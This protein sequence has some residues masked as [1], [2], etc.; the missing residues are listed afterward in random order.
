M[1]MNPQQP[2]AAHTPLKA[3][4]RHL[5]AFPACAEV[6]GASATGMDWSDVLDSI[7]DAILVH[8]LASGRVLHANAGACRMF[9][10]DLGMLRRR[11]FGELG[12]GT[13]PHGDED[14]RRWFERATA[15]GPQLFEWLARTAD[16]RCFWTEVGLHVGPGIAA[17]RCFATVRDISRRKA[18]AAESERATEALRLSEERFRLLLGRMPTVAVQ[19]CGPDGTVRYWNEASERLYGYSAAEAVGRHLVALI[20]PPPLRDEMSVTLHQ[21]LH[22]GQPLPPAEVQLQRKDGSLVSVFSSHTVV[23]LAGSGPE[24]FR[25]DF[26]LSDRKRAEAERLELERRLLHSRKL[27]SL[28]VLAGGIAH[29]F[30]NLLTGVLGNLE[31]ARNE[32]PPATPAAPLIDDAITAGRLAANLTH[33][34]LAYAGRTHLQRSPLDLGAVVARQ[35]PLLQAATAGRATLSLDLAPDLPEIEADAD[36]IGQLLV[37]LVTN[38]AESIDSGRIGTVEVRTGLVEHCP[39]EVLADSRL[40]EKP[41]PQPFVELE[42]AD[43]GAGMDAA[44]AQRVFDPFFSTRFAGPR[45]GLPVAL[46]IVRGPRRGNL[47]RQSSRP[48]KRHQGSATLGPSAGGP[49]PGHGRTGR[50]PGR[51]AFG[52]AAAR[53]RRRGCR[54]PHRRAHGPAARARRDHRTR[55]RVRPGAFAPPRRHTRLRAHRPHDARNERFRVPADAARDPAR[56]SGGALQLLRRSGDHRPSDVRRF[57]RFPAKAIHVRPLCRAHPGIDPAHRVQLRRGS[58]RPQPCLQ[59]PREFHC[60]G[61]TS[62]PTP[63]A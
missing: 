32:L 19:G 12:A 7:G 33:Q 2:S 37:N 61:T 5:E 51:R 9:G 41:S 22:T 58:A 52:R 28:G 6:S 53:R 31:L 43:D 13:P 54:A 26:D 17:D 21:M 11:T 3:A 18:L 16:G 30:N 57:R 63:S 46:G 8:E 39:A 10:Y 15:E 36:Q 4:P 1:P 14:A 60:R 55:R 40:D 45:L 62:S 25:L 20:V 50:G 42:V 35:R 24:L 23:S 47:P 34:M 44:T 29:D 38:A 48:G 27:E 56:A 49:N 59:A